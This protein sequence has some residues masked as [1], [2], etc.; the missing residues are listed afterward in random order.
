MDILESL[1]QRPGMPKESLLRDMIED[2]EIDLKDLL[3]VEKL[4]DEHRSI[5]KEL[6]LIKINHDG[7][8]G[9]ASESYSG[10]STTYLDDLP[11][12]LRR[13]INSKRKLPR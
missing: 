12:T 13:K 10:H 3:H 5:L 9:I 2:C 4:T 7:V 6:V 11:K 8:E 1:M